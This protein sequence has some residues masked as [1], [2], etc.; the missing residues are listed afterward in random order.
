MEKSLILE[1]FHR[2]QYHQRRP[3]SPH[4]CFYIFITAFTHLILH[5]GSFINEK[6]E[7]NAV[8]TLF[9]L[10]RPTCVIIIKVCR[11]IFFQK[12]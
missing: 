3:K 5:S 2:G 1:V 11:E 12:K 7:Q 8:P 10:R 4:S 9:E 6:N